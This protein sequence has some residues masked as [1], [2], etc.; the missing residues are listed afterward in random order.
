MRALISEPRNDTQVEFNRLCRLGGGPRGGPARGKVCELLRASARELN[1][2]AYG[3][4]ANYLAAYPNANPWHICFAFGLGWGHL[5]KLDV[6]FVGAVVGVLSSWNDADL[7]TACT[8]HLER[9][10][11]PIEQSLIGAH[12]L[13][14]ATGARLPSTLPD[15]LIGLRDAQNRWIGPLIQASGQRVRPRYIGNWNAV[16]MFMAALFA[17]PALARTLREPGTGPCLPSG[18]PT[19]TGLQLLRRISRWSTSRSAKTGPLVGTTSA[20]T[21]SKTSTFVRPAKFSPRQASCLT[22]GRHYTTELRQAIAAAA[23]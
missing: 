7:Q 6:D 18:G 13:F 9:G 1:E 5:A 11:K 23:S 12:M 21:R 10:A 4:M 22:M 8:F 2:F 3:E 19:Y 20:L 17:Q 15:T 16:A 14:T